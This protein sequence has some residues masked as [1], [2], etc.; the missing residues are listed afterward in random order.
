MYCCIC[1][2]NNEYEYSKQCHTDR[3]HVQ[4]VTEITGDEEDSSQ[5]VEMFST[6]A[7]YL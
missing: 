4:I 6:K 3:Q 2:S 7:S 5:D 1:F